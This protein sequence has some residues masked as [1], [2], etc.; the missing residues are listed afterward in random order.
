MATP[1]YPSFTQQWHGPIGSW[2]HYGAQKDCR[3]FPCAPS[4]GQTLD[5]EV[6]TQLEPRPI[7]YT[8]DHAA[9]LIRSTMELAQRKPQLTTGTMLLSFEEINNLL[10]TRKRL[11][12]ELN[13]LHNGLHKIAELI[14]VDEDCPTC[15]LLKKVKG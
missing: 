10:D 15:E 9:F 2:A 11:L 1:S 7:Q 6:V 13:Q 8:T 5:G 12:V 3:R 14:Q 4:N